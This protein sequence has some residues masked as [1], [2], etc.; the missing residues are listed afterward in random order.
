MIKDGKDLNVSN[1][2]MASFTYKLGSAFFAFLL[3][4]SW[5]WYANGANGEWTTLLTA[6]AQG[7]SSFIVTLVLVE[8]VMRLYH[9]FKHPL[10]RILLS[11]LIVTMLSASLLL[12]IHLGVGTKQIL[13]TII[14]PSTVAF[15]FC[16]YTSIKVHKLNAK[17]S[18]K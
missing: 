5:A 1:Y 10:A 13:Q 17:G 4:G 14:P 2:S 15:L 8:L 3:W 12:F 18:F 16:L 9:L 7:I 6:I 11:A